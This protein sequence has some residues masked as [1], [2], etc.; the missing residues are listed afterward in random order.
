VNTPDGELELGASEIARFGA[1]VTHETR[2]Q[3]RRLIAAHVQAGNPAIQGRDGE[4]RLSQTLR[5]MWRVP[6]T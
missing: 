6:P 1:I 4:R 3:G 5:M 2:A